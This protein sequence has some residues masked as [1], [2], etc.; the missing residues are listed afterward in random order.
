MCS[1]GQ[2][3]YKYEVCLSMHACTFSFD[4]VRGNVDHASCTMLWYWKM[5]CTVSKRDLGAAL[6][7]SAAISVQLLSQTA[8]GAKS[9]C[10]QSNSLQLFIS[11]ASSAPAF[12]H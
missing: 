12:A 3:K 1:K 2:Y 9:C 11:L 4:N 5:S 6:S 7:V 10:P 8:V